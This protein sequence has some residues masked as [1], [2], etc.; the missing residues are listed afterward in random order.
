VTELATWRE[1]PQADS[2]LMFGVRSQEIQ[3]AYDAVAKLVTA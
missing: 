3:R 2:A 1:G